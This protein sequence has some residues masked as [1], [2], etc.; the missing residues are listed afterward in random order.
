MAIKIHFLEK[1][2]SEIRKHFVE[3]GQIWGEYISSERKPW[4]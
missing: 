1:F 4:R 2:V 3:Y